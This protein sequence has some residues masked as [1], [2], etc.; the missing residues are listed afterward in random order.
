MSKKNK[1]DIGNN[2]SG[3]Y[4]LDNFDDELV[5]IP[6]KNY[7]DYGDDFD[8]QTGSNIKKYN[9]IND[10]FLVFSDEDNTEFIHYNDGFNGEEPVIREMTH[11]PLRKLNF[12]LR[13][14]KNK[15][16]AIVLGAAA[17]VFLVLAVVF[18]LTKCSSDKKPNKYA[19]T[20]AATQ[21]Q[22]EISSTAEEVTTQQQTTQ[23]PTEKPTQKPTTE[24]VTTEQP[25]EQITEIVTEP[26][27]TE[28]ATEAYEEP[29]TIPPTEYVE[30]AT[31]AP[32]E[33][34]APQP[35]ED[36]QENITVIEGE[37]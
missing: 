30:P 2:R 28:P 29:P 19:T 5:Y 32:V 10:D 6:K 15:T 1:N 34:E 36:E 3:D 26:I 33:T 23:K 8:C 11:R 14:S 25:T 20:V 12:N 7:D 9:S 37:E 16:V 31:E 27:V 18:T 13:L 21:Q 4:N 17:L 22:T 35:T 24:P